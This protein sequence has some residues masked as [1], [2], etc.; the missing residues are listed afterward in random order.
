MRKW[1]L[2]ERESEIIHETGQLISKYNTMIEQSPLLPRWALSKFKASTED[3]S[4]DEDNDENVS[5]DNT[6]YALA[7]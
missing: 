3:L 4:S 2:K 6:S 5:I 7:A 1:Q